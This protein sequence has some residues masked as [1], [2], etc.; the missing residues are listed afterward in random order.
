MHHNFMPSAARRRGGSGSACAPLFGALTVCAF[1]AFPFL[2]FALAAVPGRMASSIL[3][4]EMEKPVSMDEA[5][6]AIS[7]SVFPGIIDCLLQRP[8][9][10]D[11]QAGPDIHINYPSIGNAQIDEDIRD[12][13]TGLADA[14]AKHLDM[15]GL[16]CSL[17][18]NIL[19]LETMLENPQDSIE[20]NYELRG[21]YKVSRPSDKAVSIA[22][23]IWNYTGNPEANLDI[24]TLN[25]SLLTGQRLSFVDI[26]EKPDIALEL[27]SKWSR[28]VLEP[29]LGASRRAAML[30][31][32]TAP[33]VENFSSITLTPEGI[34][35]NFQPWQ[36][37]SKEA[38][39]Q[40]VIMPLEELMPSAPLL[41]LWGK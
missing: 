34:C 5:A 25:Y 21:E 2:D 27:M 19:N 20:C 23:E 22:F 39:I 38:G 6:S 9:A 40:K 28:K 37:A 3:P 4:Q 35:I 29:R 8:T 33:Y 16:G 14:F 17:D 12:W 15:N 32:G 24:L 10:G 41:A 36:V 1:M 11:D 30:A 13:V 31:Q 18:T 26:F 7:G